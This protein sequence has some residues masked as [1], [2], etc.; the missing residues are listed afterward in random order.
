MPMSGRN[1]PN[2][3]KIVSQDSHTLRIRVTVSCQRRG[4]ATQFECKWLIRVLSD[5]W[6][7]L[8]GYYCMAIIVW[9]IHKFLSIVCSYSSPYIFPQIQI[10]H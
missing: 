8:S 5:F 9:L 3:P 7:L 6:L 2:I 10:G 4:T 1:V